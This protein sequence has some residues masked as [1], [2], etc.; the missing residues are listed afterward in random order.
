MKIF[1]LGATGMLG[2]RLALDLSASNKVTCLLRK[3]DILKQHPQF[4]DMHTIDNIDVETPEGLNHLKYLIQNQK[5]KYLINAV[6]VIK[7]RE[8][9]KN[10]VKTV[11]LN[12]LLPH[13]LADICQETSTKLITFSTD[14]VFSG[15]KGGY[16]D[17]DIPDPIDLYGKSKST[18]EVANMPHCL[19]IR[20]SII[21]RELRDG[22]GLVEWFIKQENKTINGFVNAIYSGLTTNCMANL[23]GFLISNY[24]DIYG[25]HTIS[26]DS[27]SKF[28]LL[29]IIKN[30]YNLDII[31]NKNLDFHCD[32]SLNSSSF[33]NLY[34]WKP[35][36]WKEMIQQ[37]YNQDFLITSLNNKIK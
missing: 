3:I 7:Q 32:R 17:N 6:G 34:N 19:T 20:S 4:K 29:T 35:P 22:L 21:G 31:I 37:M 25:V 36:S 8:E 1:I 26:S 18:G 2:H 14:C 23:I 10:A 33:Q 5:P 27:I 9:C 13:I 11:Y 24:P 15:K 16:T 28:D 12:S 30:I